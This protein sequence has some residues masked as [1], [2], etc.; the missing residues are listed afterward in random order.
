M[1][2]DIFAA[3]VILAV[4]AV[5]LAIACGALDSG[6]READLEIEYGDYSP[7]EGDVLGTSGPVEIVE[8]GGQKYLHGTGIG[9]GEVVRPDGGTERIHVI[10]AACDLIIIDGQSN[11]AYANGDRATSIAPPLGRAA[12]WGSPWSQPAHLTDNLD[13]CQW[14][15]MVDPDGTLRL[16]DKGPAFA[17]AWTEQTGKKV[18]WMSVAVVGRAIADWQQPDGVMWA[19]NC[20]LMAR[21]MADL[22]DG[23]DIEDVY[24]LW[25]QGEADRA[26]YRPALYESIWTQMYN[27][28]NRGAWDCPA[29]TAWGLISG[30]TA[31]V[32]WVN[33]TFEALAERLDNVTVCVDPSLVDSF[34]PLNGLL[35]ADQVHYTQEGDN[36]VANAS[37]RYLSG[38]KDVAPIY[39]MQ[40]QITA[41]QGTEPT[42]PE[43]A[44]CYRTDGSQGAAPVAW[45]SDPDATEAGTFVIEGTATIPDSLLL[46]FTPSPVLIVTVEASP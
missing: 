19:W 44:T 18:L 10:R 17:A 41:T 1:R 3:G 37:A 8:A 26:N 42:A 32:G 12:Y 7:I 35:L 6:G 31:K 13:L 20:D 4:G 46:D 23:Y 28:V 14:R 34:T 11:A 36:A 27:S 25:A 43:V 16:A 38:A 21:A 29:P 15:D 39:L 2:G 22:P 24:V 45:D 9:Y 33:D 40:S 5:L 30:R